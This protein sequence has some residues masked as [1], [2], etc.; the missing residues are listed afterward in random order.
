MGDLS[1]WIGALYIL[2]ILR[3]RRFIGRKGNLSVSI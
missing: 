2:G 3:V 1:I